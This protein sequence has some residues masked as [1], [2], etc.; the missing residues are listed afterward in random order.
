MLSLVLLLAGCGGGES[1]TAQ[2]SKTQFIKQGDKICAA[3]SEQA[4]QALKAAAKDL[5]PGET[6]TPQEAEE[7]V[8]TQT[9]PAME[10]AAQQLTQLATQTGEKKAEEVAVT[11]KDGVKKAMKHPR[12][13][14]VPV[15]S[16]GAL[17]DAVRRGREMA[18]AYGFEHC[19]EI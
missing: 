13:V 4:A 10:S 17:A 3:A 6:F 11:I 5:K 12:Q 19:T 14:L 15:E 1:T 8:R 9:L 7:I 18:E 16:H 2:L